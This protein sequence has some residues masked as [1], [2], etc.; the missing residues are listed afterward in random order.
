[1]VANCCYFLN[2]LESKPV[3]QYPDC[4]YLTLYGITE[5]NPVLLAVL[6][7]YIDHLNA[8]D[9]KYL[10]HWGPLLTAWP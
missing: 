1:M 7:E 5:H 3:T 2:V 10:Q 4:T 6:L 8:I 9:S